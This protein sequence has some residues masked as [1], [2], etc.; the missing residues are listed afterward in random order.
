MAPLG[1]EAPDFDL[2]DPEGERHSL[3]DFADDPAL[4]V[5][6]MCNHCPYV[7]HLQD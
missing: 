3:E 7:K 5:V 1:M 6:F 4:V 2:P